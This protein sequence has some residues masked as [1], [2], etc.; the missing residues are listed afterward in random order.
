LLF[1]KGFHESIQD[2]EAT[3]VSSFEDVVFVKDVW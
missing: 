3:I 1:N 2:I